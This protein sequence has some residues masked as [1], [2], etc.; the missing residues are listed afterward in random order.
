MKNK[1]NNNTDISQTNVIAN[2]ITI[3]NM[4]MAILGLSS[5]CEA[6]CVLDQTTAE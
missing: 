6:P 2:A 5:G 1:Y 3:A 4:I